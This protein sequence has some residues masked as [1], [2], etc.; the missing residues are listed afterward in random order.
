MLD[1]ITDPISVQALLKV[2]LVGLLIWAAWQ[3]LTRLKIPNTISLAVLGLFPLYAWTVPGEFPWL[4][5]GLIAAVLL[6]LGIIAFSR[7]LIGG[8][9]V[10][11]LA[12]TALWAGPAQVLDFLFITAIAGGVLGLLALASA[13]MAGIG[14]GALGDGK[15]PYGV[16]IAVGGIAALTILPAFAPEIF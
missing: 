2:I 16:A 11:L 5:A 10:K 8:G 1:P 14:I 3:D 6:V 13:R 7:G 12:A 9:D 15:L 4:L